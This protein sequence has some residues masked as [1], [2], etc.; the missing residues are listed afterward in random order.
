MAFSA[1]PDQKDNIELLQNSLAHGRL[2]HAYMFDGHDLGQLEAV[3][4]TLAKALNCE[5]P[6]TRGKSGLALDS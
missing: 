5:N 2:G 3:A 1:F 6:P 4:T